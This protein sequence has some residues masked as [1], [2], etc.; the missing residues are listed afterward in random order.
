M[1]FTRISKT[2]AASR[3]SCDLQI[4]ISFASPFVNCKDRPFASG[5]RKLRDPQRVKVL[6]RASRWGIAISA[7]IG[8]ST[9][10]VNDVSREFP[11]F[12]AV[13]RGGKCAHKKSE[14]APGERARARRTVEGE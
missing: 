1:Y 2:R 6:E 12:S 3:E 9:E 7:P 8:F 13:S 11:L 5:M 4:I 14:R 10:Q